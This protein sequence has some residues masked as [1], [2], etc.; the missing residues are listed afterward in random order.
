MTVVTGI[1][2]VS[3]LYKLVDFFGNA[4]FV[5]SW[6]I[7]GQLG[8]VWPRIAAMFE[9]VVTLVLEWGWLL[10]PI[11]LMMG[12]SKPRPVAWAGL[13][14]GRLSRRSACGCGTK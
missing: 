5:G 3:A 8:E 10:S 14:A 1:P 11:P 13:A 6:P 2:L 7:W 9:R 4:Q 12:S